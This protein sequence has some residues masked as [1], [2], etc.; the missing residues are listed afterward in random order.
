[1]IPNKG[2]FNFDEIWEEVKAAQKR[3]RQRLL[4]ENQVRRAVSLREYS[5]KEAVVAWGG[6]VPNCYKYRAHSTKLYLYYNGEFKC[7]RNFS[8]TRSFARGNW[9]FETGPLFGIIIPSK[10]PRWF[11]K[12]TNNGKLLNKIQNNELIRIILRDRVYG[13]IVR[14]LQNN[15]A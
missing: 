12:I 7:E 14:E 10:Y 8:C 1:M 9:L 5:V 13:L 4:S 3:C 11:P 15:Y 6:F 2:K